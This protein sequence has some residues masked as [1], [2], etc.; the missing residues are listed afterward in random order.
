MPFLAILETGAAAIKSPYN[1]V[2]G[3]VW[4]GLVWFGATS[5]SR[6]EKQQ[7]LWDRCPVFRQSLEQDTKAKPWTEQG[8]YQPRLDRYTYASCMAF[9]RSNSRERD[10][11]YLCMVATYVRT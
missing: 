8:T 1:A 6:K 2:I 4:F 9:H 5:H 11:Y 7:G 3:L 10:C